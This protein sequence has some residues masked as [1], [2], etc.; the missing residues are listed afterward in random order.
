MLSG[1][2]IAD[3]SG[4]PSRLCL[5]SAFTPNAPFILRPVFPFSHLTLLVIESLLYSEFSFITRLFL[6]EEENFL[7]HLTACLLLR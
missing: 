2:M 4:I 6:K 5:I 1:L 7:S 3:M